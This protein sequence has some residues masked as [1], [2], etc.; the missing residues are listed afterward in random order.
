MSTDQGSNAISALRGRDVGTLASDYT[1]RD[2]ILYALAVGARADELSL[3]YERDMRALPTIAMAMG[4]WAVE[5]VHAS[6][7][8][9]PTRALHVSQQ[10][11]MKAPL[12]PAGTLAM[13]A[14]VAEVWDKGSAAVLEIEVDSEE[15]IATYGIYVPGAGGWGG[16]RG[17]GREAEQEGAPEVEFLTP[18]SVRQAVLYRLTGDRHPVHVDPEVASAGGFERP[19]L[20]GL[21]T[22]GTVVLSLAREVGSDPVSL[23]ELRAGFTAPVLPGDGLSTRA[24][25]C[26]ESEY[27]FETRVSGRRVL[28]G[29]YAL[30]SR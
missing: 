15:F 6:G 19:I 3:V 5:R 17:P 4:L 12:G 25:A 13:G 29:G 21:C 7:F 8:Y 10:L 22:L 24:W 18:T 11:R 30:F 28:A 1:E 20:H 26:D 9:D 2:A 23:T 27:S 14:R 16:D